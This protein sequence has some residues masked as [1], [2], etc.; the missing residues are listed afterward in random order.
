MAGLDATDLE[1][2]F[3]NGDPEAVLDFL[4]VRSR[5]TVGHGEEGRE[6]EEGGGGLSCSVPAFTSD[7]DM[8]AFVRDLT[9]DDAISYCFAHLPSRSD[10]GLTS[11]SQALLPTRPE[12]KLTDPKVVAAAAEPV[13]KQPSPH[14]ASRSATVKQQQ[15]PS[16]SV[17][18]SVRRDNS[19]DKP[20]GFLSSLL[21]RGH[22]GRRGDNQEK[23]AHRYQ[24]LSS[25]HR[26]LPSS[27]SSSEE[28]K[29]K[30]ALDCE[31]GVQTLL[32]GQTHF[33]NGPACLSDSDVLPGDLT[34][35]HEKHAV[36]GRQQTA[37]TNGQ[38]VDSSRVKE[39]RRVRQVT[40][41]SD[42][43]CVIEYCFSPTT[44][45]HSD[46]VEHKLEPGGQHSD[47]SVVPKT[48]VHRKTAIT[49]E[50][51][52]S[53][54]CLHRVAKRLQ[55]NDHQVFP[56]PSVPQALRSSS[57]KQ[58]ENS[59]F[60]QPSERIGNHP[61]KIHPQK[62][63]MLSSQT[64]P[65]APRGPASEKILTS[66]IVH[67][68]E[69]ATHKAQGGKDQ[70]LLPRKSWEGI[71]DGVD[72]FIDF[73]RDPN[74]EVPLDCHLSAQFDFERRH[75]E[76]RLQGDGEQTKVLI[77][78]P[79][80]SEMSEVPNLT[81]Q[82]SVLTSTERVLGASDENPVTANPGTV[83]LCDKTAS[84]CASTTQDL[85][86]F[87]EATLI[88]LSKVSTSTQTENS[89]LE[90]V[91]GS[92]SPRA[93]H[94]L[95]TAVTQ[96]SA[97][98]ACSTCQDVISRTLADLKKALL[99]IE[100]IPC[101]ND[102]TPDPAV[103]HAKP[104]TPCL[105]EK[106]ADNAVL[107]EAAAGEPC[108]EPSPSNAQST[109]TGTP[110]QN[111]SQNRETD[112]QGHQI[113][114][115]KAGP[116]SVSKTSQSRTRPEQSTQRSQQAG[117]VGKKQMTSSR[118]SVDSDSASTS[119]VTS[120][121]VTVLVCQRGNRSSSSGSSK[122]GGPQSKVGSKVVLP[123]SIVD[124]DSSFAGKSELADCSPSFGMDDNPALD[125]ST[126]NTENVANPPAGTTRAATVSLRTLSRSRKDARR[127]APRYAGEAS[128]R[129]YESFIT[130]SWSEMTS[131]SSVSDIMTSADESSYY[132]G[133]DDDDNEEEEDEEEEEEEE[134]DLTTAVRLGLLDEDRDDSELCQH[135]LQR[136]LAAVLRQTSMPT[137]TVETVVA[138][139]G[140]RLNGEERKVKHINQGSLYPFSSRSSTN[141]TAAAGSEAAPCSAPGLGSG[142]SRADGCL[143]PSTGLQADT[144]SASAGREAR[145]ARK[146]KKGARLFS[147]DRQVSL[148]SARQMTSEE[149]REGYDRSTDLA[150]AKRSQ[151]DGD[152][153]WDLIPCSDTDDDAGS[154]KA[155]YNVTSEEETLAHAYG[156]D[157]DSS[158]TTVS[159]W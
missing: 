158:T 67:S 101:E 34:D 156:S 41:D 106:Q 82:T 36:A 125:P 12:K 116:I 133:D 110:S 122:V 71:C 68:A 155:W 102:A 98:A 27:T 51:G 111:W 83:T 42:P 79:L 20:R 2:A 33:V 115:P 138:A 81:L 30:G 127:N 85:Y 57:S 58:T 134:D 140:E 128:D 59:V 103:P 145:T 46:S 16:Q 76:G 95:R 93:S 121:P 126:M 139:T 143:P 92:V 35:F 86:P 150:K 144:P 63:G 117:V 14:T 112:L 148:I 80:V 70:T 151:L 94:C 123:P 135:R 11:S 124:V 55:G 26:H 47:P 108:E 105:E 10:H 9:I 137:S 37:D 78:R 17:S 62:D 119:T 72:A 89:N 64:H 45:Q 60:N 114:R 88:T 29:R 107:V 100:S 28:E 87:S 18:G 3:T 74:L 97:L 77:N 44:A 31:P 1:K 54:S 142:S 84:R 61:N 65:Q 15:S 153:P 21:G 25:K 99:E 75:S 73:E 130:S 19:R 50:L 157:T 23:P 4:V 131:V 49:G 146:A 120:E 56:H 154:G 129:D 24:D 39:D 90:V 141:A 69:H 149:F 96:L 13:Q 147:P 91:E 52:S 8:A 6:G 118:A 104:I 132:S 38:H 7:N 5:R 40:R 159:D 22:K 66:A 48:S 113:S 53:N 109:E 136:H 32:C 43:V 152:I